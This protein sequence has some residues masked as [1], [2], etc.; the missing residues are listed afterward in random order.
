MNTD[1][2]TVADGTAIGWR[3]TGCGPGIVVVHGGATSSVEYA[4]FGSLLGEQYECFLVDRRGRGLSGSQGPAY[5]LETEVDDVAAVLARTGADILFGHS[6]GALVALHAALTAQLRALI[7]YE[8]PLQAQERA[9][10]IIG[11]F[12]AALS[13]E[14]VV[15]AYVTLAVG[16]GVIG[17]SE[18]QF[19][20]FV[21]TQLQPTPRWQS[22]V[23]NLHAAERELKV[24][25]S[26]RLE[27]SRYAA[28]ATP[29][30]V[31]AGSHSPTYLAEP[32]RRLAEV[33]ACSRLHVLGGQGHTATNDDPTAVA[34]AIAEFL[35]S[36][37][38]D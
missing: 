5:A 24:A 6:Y 18:E 38:S 19:R 32:S 3:T 27:W 31:L 14:D 1:T 16:L 13:R 10:E 12:R 23:E 8:P 33:L 25:A 2:V 28:L 26:F 37:A 15:E 21:T 36:P 35:R 7:L 9:A 4:A 34:G 30:L 29:T 11:P 20:W 22:V 17:F